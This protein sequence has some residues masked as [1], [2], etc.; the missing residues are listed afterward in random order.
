MQVDIGYGDAVTPGPEN[1]TYPVLL[2]NL[3]PP[4]LKVYPRYTVVA[5]KFEAIVSLGMANSR[6][7]DY[8]DLWILSQHAK[9]EESLLVEAIVATFKRRKTALPINIPLGL[10][11]VFYSDM[12]KQTQ[13]KAF[14]NK[15]K[16]LAS[17]LPETTQTITSFLM[18]II[19]A[20]Q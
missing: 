7:K 1:A 20:I 19:K 3:P 17:S 14:L 4:Q 11:S 9:F 10:S 16:L 13:W 6:L 8:F 15:N 12:Q 5:E 2:N 18:P